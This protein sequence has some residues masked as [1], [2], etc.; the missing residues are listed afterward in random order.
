MTKTKDAIEL[1]YVINTTPGILFNRL[2]TASGL[3]EWF[4]DD[5]KVHGNTFTFKWDVSEQKAQQS[6]RRENK[7]VRYTWVED[8]ELE[9][10]W[11]EFNINVDDL[12]GDVALVIIDHVDKDEIEDTIELWNRQIEILKRGL[13]SS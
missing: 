10:V 3:S 8:E 13:G 2:S 6:M 5:V 11:F 9:G 4:A 1:E 12:T 7:M